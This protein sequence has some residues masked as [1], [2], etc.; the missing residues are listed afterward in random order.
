MKT[1]IIDEVA[2][3]YVR[4]SSKAAAEKKFLKAIK[5]TG[6]VKVTCEVHERDVYE[7]PENRSL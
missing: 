3:Y 1:Y 4:A 2:T 7:D 5:V 6:N